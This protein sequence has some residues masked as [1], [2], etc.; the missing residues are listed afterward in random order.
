LKKKTEK[1]YFRKILTK[2]SA[3]KWATSK[4]ASFLLLQ[5]DKY[6]V[7]LGSS[8]C[9]KV[10]LCVIDMNFCRLFLLF[11]YELFLMDPRHFCKL[12]PKCLC[13]T[14]DVDIQD[15]NI[16]SLK[17]KYLHSFLYLAMPKIH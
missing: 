15:C 13:N 5:A 6:A 16:L 11:V 2:K 8:I 17:L 12:N 7:F 3:P 4:K 9:E 1:N 14:G 10:V